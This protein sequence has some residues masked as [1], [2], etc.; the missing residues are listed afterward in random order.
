M[1]LSQWLMMS[2]FVVA[3]GMS[4]SQIF[5]AEQACPANFKI[6]ANQLCKCASAE[7]INCALGGEV[8]YMRKKGVDIKGKTLYTKSG[9]AVMCK[10]KTWGVRMVSDHMGFR[11]IK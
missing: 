6:A 7:T 5:A 11:C 10:G 3:M 1:K 2:G 9:T 8:Q 4:S